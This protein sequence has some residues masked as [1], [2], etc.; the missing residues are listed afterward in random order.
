M[1]CSINSH[2]RPTPLMSGK[3]KIK[4]ELMDFTVYTESG[5]PTAIVDTED[6]PTTAQGNVQT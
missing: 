2:C 1:T 6:G 3:R 4:A 5:E